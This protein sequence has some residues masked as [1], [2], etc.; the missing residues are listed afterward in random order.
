MNLGFGFFAVTTQVTFWI[1]YTQIG[2][3]SGSIGITAGIGIGLGGVLYWLGQLNLRKQNI[4]VLRAS[5][6]DWG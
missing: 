2:N 3:I 5:Y 4:L 6:C 1:L